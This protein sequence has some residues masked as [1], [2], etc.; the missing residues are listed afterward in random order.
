MYP[1]NPLYPSPSPNNR[2]NNRP[3]PSPS[4]SPNNRRNNRPPTSPS[5]SPNNRRNNRHSPRPSPSPSPKWWARPSPGW[6]ANSNSNSNGGSKQYIKLQSGGKRL[7][8]TGNRGGKYY[9]KGGQN[10]YIK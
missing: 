8:H 5:P 7:I 2:R 4:P 3:W 10:I 1:N 9:I 6:W